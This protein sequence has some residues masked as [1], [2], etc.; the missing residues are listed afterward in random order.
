[1]QCCIILDK[2]Q[3]QVENEYYFIDLPEILKK[4]NEN[5]AAGLLQD[6]QIISYPHIADEKAR[7]DIFNSI[8]S[9]LPKVPEEVKS[10]DD[11]YEALKRKMNMASKLG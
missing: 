2:T 7:S 1:M 11:Q 9:Q 10:A 4:K 3:H 6:I 8:K 5:K